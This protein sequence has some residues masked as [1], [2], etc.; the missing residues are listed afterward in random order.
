MIDHGV[1][2]KK[3]GILVGRSSTQITETVYR[4]QAQAR[5]PRRR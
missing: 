5:D 2:M 4:H 3:I 1:P